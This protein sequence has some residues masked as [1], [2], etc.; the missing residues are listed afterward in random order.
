MACEEAWLPSYCSYLLT[1]IVA[2]AWCV[3]KMDTFRDVLG[4]E[5][6]KALNACVKVKIYGRRANIRSQKYNW[7]Q[8]L[9]RLRRCFEGVSKPLFSYLNSIKYFMLP[10]DENGGPNRKKIFDIFDI[11]D[12][13]VRCDELPYVEKYPRPGPRYDEIKELIDRRRAE[14]ERQCR[15]TTDNPEQYSWLVAERLVRDCFAGGFPRDQGLVVDFPLSG[16]YMYERRDNYP[17]SH[18][19]RNT[20]RQTRQKI[21]LGIFNE[22]RE[23]QGARGDPQGWE[24]G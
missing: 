10:P 16:S 21:C 12:A 19:S 11:H 4:R 5:G 22:N 7:E 24:G 8:A 20:Q 23:T 9:S 13:L 6:R 3:V 14:I 2:D 17:L 15:Q 18:P 1:V